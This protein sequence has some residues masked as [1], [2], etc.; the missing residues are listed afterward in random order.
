MI[1]N[2]KDVSVNEGLTDI[3]REQ[4]AE[5][6][7]ELLAELGL[8]SPVFQ[9]KNQ[10]VNTMNEY[11][12]IEADWKLFRKLLPDWQERYMGTL[13]EE[14]KQIISKDDNPSAR[15]WELDERI[16]KDKKATGVI[17]Q[18]VSRSNM[19]FIM[20]DLIGER[21]ITK[22]DLEG[23]SDEY[24]ELLCSYCDRLDSHIE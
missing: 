6:Q 4:Q 24:R 13:L 21:A 14:Y 10:R 15:F 16:K 1:E 20:M 23:F 5:F 8:I 7:L 12:F 17:A 19:K 18:R 3:E 11:G 22:D 9:C 2:E